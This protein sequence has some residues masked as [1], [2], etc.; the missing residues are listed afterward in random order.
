MKS[1]EPNMHTYYKWKE[2]LTRI[3]H[4]MRVEATGLQNIPPAGGGLLT[5]N[6]LNWKD[7]LFIATRSPR[8]LHYVATHQLFDVRRCTE[9]FYEYLSPKLDPWLSPFTWRICHFLA[10]N[11]VPGVQRV[12]TIPTTRG[13]HDRRMFTELKQALREGQ[14]ACI[15]AEGGTSIPGTIR[16]F[17]KGAAKVIYDLYTEGVQDIPIIPTLV[18]GTD[19][20]YI[21]GRRL[22]LHFGR[23]LFI[24]N[25]ICNESRETIVQF[26]RQ[27]E[28]SVRSL[29]MSRQPSESGGLHGA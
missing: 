14:L 19:K 22:G 24:R 23:P 6:H 21:P 27:L 29:L 12:G 7:V 8:P 16:K 20:A 18:T 1:T 2:R 10:R 9:M 25:H 5:A 17:K 28:N 26:T 4:T 11:I 15:F 3:L 13:N